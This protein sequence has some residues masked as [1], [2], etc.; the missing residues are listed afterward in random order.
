MDIALQRRR[1][2]WEQEAVC[3]KL[4]P[5]EREDFFPPRGRP[6]KNP[7]W[8]Q[9][10]FTC[11]VRLECLNYAIVH[12]EDGNW[13][14]STERERKAL[15]RSFVRELTAI[16]MAAGWYEIHPD[17]LEDYK[18]RGNRQDVQFLIDWERDFPSIDLVSGDAS[19]ASLPLTE[20]QQ[21]SFDLLG[22]Y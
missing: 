9:V 22:F 11:P 21:R 8:K 14:G 17:P 18:S 13:G 10:C 2:E 15:P 4:S 6:S 5:Q 16:A 20:E 1:R 3:C 7:H 19:A 12:E